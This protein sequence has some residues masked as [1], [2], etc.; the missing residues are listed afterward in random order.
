MINVLTVLSVQIAIDSAIFPE[1]TT[2]IQLDVLA[3]KALWSEGLN[4]LVS[5]YVWKSRTCID[6][7]LQHGTGHGF[8]SFL[9]VHEGPHSFSSAVPLQP[10]YV[11]TN[12]PGFC[13]SR[14]SLQSTAMLTNVSDNA[15]NWGMRIESALAVRRVKTKREFGGDIW[16]GFERLTVVPIQTKMVKD[17]MLSKEE[18]TW[19]RVGAVQ[20][21]L[22]NDTDHAC[23]STTAAATRSSSRTSATTSARSSGC[24]ARPSGASAKLPQGP[25]GSLSTGTR[26]PHMT[27]TFW[28]P[29]LYMR[30]YS[31][32][33]TKRVPY[34]LHPWCLV[35]FFLF[36]LLLSRRTRRP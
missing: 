15:G 27:T 28:I 30:D 31:P 36:S 12:E 14:R 33:P 2:G 34:A 35:V 3:R 20:H 23:R 16:F 21:L 29:P 26:R 22:H 24:A 7:F 25:A 9:T 17:A 18:K 6:C 8:G 11:I 19:L 1:G 32:L 4:Y 13:A 10:G 5:G